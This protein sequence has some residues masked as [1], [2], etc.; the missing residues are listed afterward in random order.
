MLATACDLGFE[1]T[2]PPEQVVLTLQ[3]LRLGLALEFGTDPEHV[4]QA[5]VTVVFSDTLRG[6][7]RTSARCTSR[8]GA[9]DHALRAWWTCPH[10][11]ATSP[12]CRSAARR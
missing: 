10:A 11:H 2:V 7:I 9:L 12:M 4:D 1:L 5:T 8:R 6:L 3:S